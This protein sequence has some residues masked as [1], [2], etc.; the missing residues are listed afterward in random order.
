[1][2]LPYPDMT[3][4][5]AD[6]RATEE[7]LRAAVESTRLRCKQADRKLQRMTEKAHE[8]GLDRVDSAY[9]TKQAAEELR[10]ALRV[11]RVAVQRFS[12]FIV[13]KKLPGRGGSKL[14]DRRRVQP[15]Y[16]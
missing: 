15:R 4:R 5:L 11:H 16:D 12:D 9:A 6:Q 13:R 3:I 2:S 14:A 10:H 8:I 1:M 7:R